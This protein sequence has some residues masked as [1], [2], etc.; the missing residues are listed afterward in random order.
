VITLFF[1]TRTNRSSIRELKKSPHI[2]F[3]GFTLQISDEHP[4]T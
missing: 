1:F 4:E 2:I 3:A